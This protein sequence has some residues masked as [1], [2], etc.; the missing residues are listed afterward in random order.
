MKTKEI[1]DLTPEEITIKLV[2]K[3]KELMEIKM[4]HAMRSLEKVNLIPE[5]RKDIAKMLTI[6]KEKQKGAK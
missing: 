2:E 4:K 6:L 1:R 3:K 5:V